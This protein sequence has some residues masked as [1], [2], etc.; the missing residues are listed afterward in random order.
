MSHLPADDIVAKHGKT[1]KE[2]PCDDQLYK[3]TIP[4]RGLTAVFFKYFI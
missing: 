3:E 4:K 1:S 2:L